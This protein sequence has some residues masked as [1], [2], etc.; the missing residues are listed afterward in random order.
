M[1]ITHVPGRDPSVVAAALLCALPPLGALAV[2]VWLMVSTPAW[3]TIAAVPFA[4]GLGFLY[5]RRMR[6]Y[7]LTVTV[8]LALPAVAG[9]TAGWLTTLQCNPDP[10]PYYRCGIES[11]FAAVIG[12]LVAL[13][14]IA[15]VTTVKA[16]ALAS[17]A[18][19]SLASR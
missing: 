12:A 6:A 5:L 7:A 19:G 8:A 16:G 9:A 17:R 1:T 4:C 14:T 10:I 15:I 2:A 18:R 3:W 13:L 11:L